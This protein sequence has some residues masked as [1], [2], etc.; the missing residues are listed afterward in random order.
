MVGGWLEEK[1]TIIRERG[2]LLAVMRKR[3][4]EDMGSVL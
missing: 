2:M 3:P 4:E 1:Q